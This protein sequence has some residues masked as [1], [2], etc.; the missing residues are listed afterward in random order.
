MADSGKGED[1]KTDL[2]LVERII[3]EGGMVNNPSQESYAKLMLGQFATE[4]LDEGMKFSPDKDVV[5]MIND[6]ISAIDSLLT[7]HLNAIMH[8]PDFQS[9]EAAWTGLRD[10]V[11]GTE[12]GPKL[13]LRLLNV[14]KKELL[15]DLET[16]VDY[17]MEKLR[18]V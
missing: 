18:W 14:S 2:S 9:L 15:K 12:T 5:A 7:D 16:A 4:L 3:E 8:D 1:V 11:F 6:R 10:M 17:E 13:K